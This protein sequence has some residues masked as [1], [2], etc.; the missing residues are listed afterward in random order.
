MKSG[1]DPILSEFTDICVIEGFAK[2][3]LPLGV[4][5]HRAHLV[6]AAHALVTLPF[7]EAVD[8]IKNGICE[9]NKRQGVANTTTSGYHETLTCFW[10]AVVLSELRDL[11]DS[12]RQ[13]SISVATFVA[14]RLAD[15]PTLWKQFY[16]YDVVR[17]TSART[18]WR[19]PDLKPL[20]DL[21][22]RSS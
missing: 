9:Y 20:P 1:T 5:N 2:H 19:E 13:D 16:S 14:D 22:A 15:H 17:C 21:T 6:V 12:L 4:W 8:F 7:E 18:S 3:E 10:I 11:P